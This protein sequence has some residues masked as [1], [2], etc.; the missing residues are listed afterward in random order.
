[1]I[2]LKRKA[3]TFML[4][5]FTYIAFGQF[6]Y[7]KRIDTAHLQNLSGSFALINDTFYIPTIF[8]E[9]WN[10]SITFSTSLIQV[11][12]DGSVITKKKFKRPKISLQNGNGVVALNKNFYSTSTSNDTITNNQRMAFYKFDS[13]SDT[14]LIK[15]YGDTVY[16]FYGFGI[17]RRLNIPNQLLIFGLTDSICGTGHP[18][19]SKPII[20]IVDT[21]G[22]VI[23]K[24]IYLTACKYHASIEATDT[25]KDKGYIFT[26]YEY[27]HFGTYGGS[28]FVIK[29]DS[30]LNTVWT[31][32][33]DTTVNESIVTLRS[34]K[35]LLSY[36]DIDSVSGTFSWSRIAL[37]KLNENGGIMW[38]K[39]YG[40]LTRNS[41]ATN[42]KELSNGDFIV[43][44][45]TDVNTV[46][47]NYPTQLYGFLMRTDSLGN[48]KWFNTY[49]ATY[50]TDTVGK[51]YLYNVLP[52]SDGGFAAV[53]FV[54]S[55]DTSGEDTWLLRVDSNGCLIPGCP[56]NNGIHHNQ[57]QIKI[58]AY[59]NPTSGNLT[60]NY[61]I[62]DPNCSYATLQL[63]ELSSGRVLLKKNVSCH[64][65]ETE[66]DLKFFANGVYTLSIQYGLSP[67]YNIKVI[68][69]D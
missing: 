49:R 35:H 25:T 69:T 22:N 51:N 30:N 50:P 53:G 20:W 48:L 17:Q 9:T 34:G 62:S 55:N 44:G 8:Y 59:P 13:S 24:K 61:F 33:Y 47:A 12:A 14:I 5:L 18:S 52:M 63:I 67:A 65:S 3:A 7:S 29:L 56:L 68:K 27:Q 41:T 42:A 54:A 26:G 2:F 11:K 64:T 60:I 31:Q 58:N 10:P 37:M 4:L 6:T 16:Y 1:M 21:M 43:C 40:N 39:K 46:S 36:G 66:I 45:G 19:N 23:S 32:Y 38:Q 28:A 15:L 57:D